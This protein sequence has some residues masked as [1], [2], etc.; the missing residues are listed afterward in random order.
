MTVAEP[1]IVL[2]GDLVVERGRVS[3]D[4]VVKDV[5]AMCLRGRGQHD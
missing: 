5:I 2:A 3:G 1:G 4:V